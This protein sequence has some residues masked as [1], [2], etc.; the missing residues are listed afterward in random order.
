MFREN[1]EFTK[2]KYEILREAGGQLMNE[3]RSKC[4][5]LLTLDYITTNN[6]K[7]FFDGKSARIKPSEI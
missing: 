3:I 4:N 6:E 7:K 5:P 2:S 1:N